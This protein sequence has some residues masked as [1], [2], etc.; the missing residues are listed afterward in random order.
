M[1]CGGCKYVFNP[2]TIRFR[3]HQ[4]CGETFSFFS[5]SILST[6]PIPRPPLCRLPGVACRLATP[7]APAD[8]VPQ[9][10]RRRCQLYRAPPQVR[11]RRA[12]SHASHTRRCRGSP[13][14][15]R[16]SLLDGAIH[17]IAPCPCTPVSR[18][19][20]VRWI[21][22]RCRRGRISTSLSVR[23]PCPPLPWT[24]TASSTPWS[25]AAR[26]GGGRVLARRGTRGHLVTGLPVARPAGHRVLRVLRGEVCD[27]GF[28]WSH[29]GGWR[30]GHG[31]WDWAGEL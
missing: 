3:S 28:V 19:T 17:R 16:L 23:S 13:S 14:A 4:T 15:R 21:G 6:S 8:A 30:R 1:I 2:P 20:A 7:A 31:S 29:E 18:P 12:P 24:Q 5:Y 9:P 11:P 10:P 26:N 27:Q 25:T 22:S